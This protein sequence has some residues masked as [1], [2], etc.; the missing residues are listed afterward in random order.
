MSVKST[1]DQRAADQLS[2]GYSQV[3][4]SISDFVFPTQMLNL[5][6]SPS[7][8]QI[9]DHIKPAVDHIEPYKD[10]DNYFLAVRDEAPPDPPVYCEHSLQCL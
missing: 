5:T 8:E 6:L 10:V 9:G 2:L 7:A 1:L 3:A 4:V